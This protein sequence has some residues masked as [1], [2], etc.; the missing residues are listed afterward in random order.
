MLALDGLGGAGDTVAM[1]VDALSI[2]L[3]RAAGR[4]APEGGLFCRLALFLARAGLGSSWGGVRARWR[5]T[6]VKAGAGVAI[7]LRDGRAS[8]STSRMSGL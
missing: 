8:A 1:S 6:G 4:R 2:V 5:G 3:A 7:D